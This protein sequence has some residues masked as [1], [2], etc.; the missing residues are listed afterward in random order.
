MTLCRR[1]WTALSGSSKAMM[2]HI[3]ID[4]IHVRVVCGGRGVVVVLVCTLDALRCGDSGGFCGQRRMTM[5]MMIEAGRQ[6]EI[7]GRIG[8]QVKGLGELFGSRC[9]SRWRRRGIVAA[10]AATR[11]RTMQEWTTQLG[12]Y[13]NTARC[14]RKGY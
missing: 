13:V 4:Q 8:R 14:T 10:A 9:G 11:G 3:R 7:E 5:M 12:R 1:R 6:G 2:A